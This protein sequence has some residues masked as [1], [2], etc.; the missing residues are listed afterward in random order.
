M[1]DSDNK[2]KLRK[3]P[4]YFRKFLKETLF[5]EAVFKLNGCTSS[6]PWKDSEKKGQKTQVSFLSALRSY[7]LLMSLH[8]MVSELAAGFSA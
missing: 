8:K 3:Y 7:R 5:L 6:S 4:T 1:K 2:E